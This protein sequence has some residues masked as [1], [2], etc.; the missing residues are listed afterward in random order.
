MPGT[1]LIGESDTSIS[2]LLQSLETTF[3]E[4]NVAMNLFK[5]HQE[6]YSTGAYTIE[7]SDKFWQRLEEVYPSFQ[8]L[9][10]EKGLGGD[11]IDLNV[12]EYVQQE[13]WDHG[14]APRQ[15]ISSEIRIYANAFLFAF[16]SFYKALKILLECSARKNELAKPVAALETAFPDI[17]AIRNSAHHM[18][19]RVRGLH[20]I[21]T[22]KSIPL[23]ETLL[24]DNLISVK[25][26]TVAAVI[27]TKYGNTLT[28]GRLAMIDVSEASMQKLQSIYQEVIN[29]FEWSGTAYIVPRI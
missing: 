29:C 12:R 8:R 2:R 22:K 23:V 17:V 3:L 4:A 6:T 20:G 26:V 24:D 18:E 25:G 7:Q 9:G 19:D 15:F 28:D 13:Q 16:D 11:K 27:G 5:K 21:H 10:Q 14:I 1:S